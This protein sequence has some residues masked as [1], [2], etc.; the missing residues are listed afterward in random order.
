[1]MVGLLPFSIVL[2]VLVSI[3]AKSITKRASAFYPV[4]YTHLIWPPGCNRAGRFHR[5]LCQLMR[6]KCSICLL[7]TSSAFVTETQKTV[8]GDVKL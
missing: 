3:F 4:S 5:A 7:Y 2:P 1:M 6:E 8:T